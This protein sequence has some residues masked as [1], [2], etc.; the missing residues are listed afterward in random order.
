M[1]DDARPMAME[2]ARISGLPLLTIDQ[3]KA[4][5]YATAF[6]EAYKQFVAPLDAMR[7]M[8]SAQFLA[9]TQLRYAPGFLVIVA[10]SVVPWLTLFPLSIRS[11]RRASPM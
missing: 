9:A 5:H 2:L 1:P 4:E 6:P 3:A 8:L 10:V 11:P 7:Q